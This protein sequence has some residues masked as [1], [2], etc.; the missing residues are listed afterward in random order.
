MTASPL[1]AAALALPSR[2]GATRSPPG[3][4]FRGWAVVAGS[5]LVQ[6][7]C[8][9]AVYSFPAFA[10]PLQASFGASDVSISL[11]YAVCGAMAFATGAVS[12]PLADRV[13]ARWPVS[14][15]MLVMAAGFLLASAAERF[16]TVLLSYGLLVGTGAGLAYV[17]A[18]AAVQRWFVTWRGLAS[19]IATAGVGAGT[20]MVPV[21]AALLSAWGDWRVSFA[22]AGTAIALLG[23]AAALLIASSPEA[24]GLRPDGAAGPAPRDESAGG[25][26]L[27]GTGLRQ[28]IRTRR[29]LG[30]VAGCFL[31]SVPVALP[32]AGIATTAREAGLDA[33]QALLLLSF[34]G[35]GSVG[36]RLLLG[37]GADRLG[38][39]RV[40]VACGLGI[41]AMMGWWACAAGPLGYALFALVFGVA[42]G[43]FVALMPGLVVDLYGRRSAGALI[44][45]LFAGR[46][47]AVLTAPP[48]AAAL[49]PV[50]GQA[51]PLWGA[52]ALAL[53][54]T[55]LLARAARRGG[56]AVRPIAPLSLRASAP[57]AART[58][59]A[60][61]GEHHLP[62]PAAPGRVPA[63]QGLRPAA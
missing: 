51:G 5:F 2:A 22:I 60:R 58:G 1:P 45:A 6:A 12:G 54:G 27:E 57:S 7:L 14:A 29:F 31:L 52:G 39:E 53:L 8:F 17:P 21:T 23:P 56:G 38:R 47:L 26:V 32:F 15:G 30:L 11:V 48:C 34:I 3:P 46:A 19:G 55:L 10:A 36:G 25:A 44:G 4:S 62:S 16:E 35:G 18:L 41:A 33:R 37:A 40:L 43:G 49:A 13:G 63:G 61:R 24:C 50:M 59:L 9:G 20:A 28:A 42:Q